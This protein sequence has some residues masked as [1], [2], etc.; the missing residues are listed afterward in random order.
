MNVLRKSKIFLVATTFL[1]SCTTTSLKQIDSFYLV[2]KVSQTG[3][4]SEITVTPDRIVIDC[5]QYSEEYLDYYWFT[6]YLLDKD[7]EAIMTFSEIKHS[8]KTCSEKKKLTEKILAKSKKIYIGVMSDALESIEKKSDENFK[9]IYFKQFNKSFKLSQRSLSFAYLQGDIGGC[10]KAVDT[11]E[12]N[13][14][15]PPA[16]FPIKE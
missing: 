11:T 13:D 10:V 8:I 6:L 16:E 14:K 4:R 15:C 9:P 2:T 12:K 3:G 1:F 5:G 7:D